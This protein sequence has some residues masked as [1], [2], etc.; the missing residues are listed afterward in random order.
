VIDTGLLV[1]GVTRVGDAFTPGTRNIPA[2]SAFVTGVFLAPRLT[3][4][5]TNAFAA[6]FFAGVFAPTTF[7]VAFFVVAT[8][9]TGFAMSLPASCGAEGFIEFTL[10]GLHA[11]DHE[12]FLGF[13]EHDHFHR[14]SLCRKAE[15]P[16]PR[17]VVVD[18]VVGNVDVLQSVS[19]VVL[20]VLA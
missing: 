1:D 3:G 5:C 14:G 6:A 12:V 2:E 15:Y 8:F 20:G 11:M 10:S 19:Y 7:F 16:G 18:H 17:R 4:V 9:F 13:M